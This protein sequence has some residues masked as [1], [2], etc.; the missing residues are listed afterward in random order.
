MFQ[1]ETLLLVVLGFS[2]A[3]LIALFAGRLM[4]S[5]AVR[6]GSR[7]MQRQIPSTAGE[8]HTERDRLR[9]EY[10]LLSQKLGSRLE[11]SRMKMAEQMAEVTRTRNRIE[12]LVAEIN[13]KDAAHAA[14]EHEIMGLHARIL[15][16]ESAAA[17]A[18]LAIAGLHL[19]LD[20]KSNEISELHHI[21]AEK[22]AHITTLAPPADVILAK[23]EPE[24]E[25]EEPAD[26]VASAPAD[27]IV[28]QHLAETAH[29]TDDLQNELNRLD[30]T[31]TK[32]LG[33][34]R[35]KNRKP[36]GTILQKDVAR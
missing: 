7:R 23:L 29:E 22:D 24:G 30:A 18:Q 25:T 5:M 6:I 31:W 32:K 35:D 28:Q 3:T 14:R 27:P 26:Q 16:N 33:R 8:L 2:L 17:E 15:E 20:G 36:G 10:A 9:A 11:S 1:T 34:I 4:W 21:I 19:D 12:T 13:E